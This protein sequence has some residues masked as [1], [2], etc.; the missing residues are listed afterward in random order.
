MMAL[1][2]ANSLR[3]SISVKNTRN[4]T[5]QIQRGRERIVLARGSLASTANVGSRRGLWLAARIRALDW[6]NG[7]NREIKGCYGLSGCRF[8]SF[9]RSPF[10]RCSP[11]RS[12]SHMGSAGRSLNAFLAFAGLFIMKM[13]IRGWTPSVPGVPLGYFPG[14]RSN[15]GGRCL[16]R[17]IICP[18]VP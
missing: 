2:M 5:R 12:T 17:P 6:R 14:V 15:S 7:R 8:A 18:V 3:R 10:A 9:R 1:P 13:A 11:S 16:L 4:A